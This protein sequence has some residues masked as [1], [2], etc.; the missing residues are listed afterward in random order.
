MEK[1]FWSKSLPVS[2]ITQTDGCQY[3]R[4]HGSKSAGQVENTCHIPYS[5]QTRQWS[6]AGDHATGDAHSLNFFLHLFSSG[7]MFL[8]PFTP[9]FLKIIQSQII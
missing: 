4:V 6:Q 5:D 2:V 9:D 3:K 1:R 8:V 7:Q